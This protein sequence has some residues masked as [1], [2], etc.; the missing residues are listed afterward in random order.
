MEKGLRG[1]VFFFLL[2]AVTFM[3]LLFVYPFAYGLYLSFTNP[4][5]APTLANYAAFFGDWWEARTIWVTLWISVPATLINMVLAIPV[6]YYMRHGLR[7]E[8]IITF[9]LIVPITLGT[10]LISEGM[11]TYMGPAGWLNQFLM[12]IGLV[13]EPIRFTHNYLGVL[14][15]LVIQGF[16]FSFLM[17]LGYVSGINPDLEKASQM[18]G[19]SKLATFRR[20]LFPL[21]VPGIA[22]SFCLNFVMMFSVF[23]SAVLLGEP[24]GPTRVMAIAAYH[25]AFEQ[26]NFNVASAISMTMAAIELLVISV[27]LVWRNRIYKGASIVGKG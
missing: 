26:F 6:A 7:G 15:S 24:S 17:L 22:I 27:V 12:L 3:V 9:F 10:V 8:K 21:M 19:A 1:T 14:L 2:P 16:P 5:G 20:I 23:P 13:K 18:L 25:W 11:L 4:N